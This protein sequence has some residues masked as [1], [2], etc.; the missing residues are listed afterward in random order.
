MR[1]LKASYTACLSTRCDLFEL[2]ESTTTLTI[3]SE[4]VG[5]ET[6]ETKT[7]SFR[8]TAGITDG[9]VAS[10]VGSRSLN[11]KRFEVWPSKLLE[12]VKMSVIFVFEARLSSENDHIEV[13]R[14]LWS[15]EYLA[16]EAPLDA[17]EIVRVSNASRNFEGR[18]SDD[19]LF[20]AYLLLVSNCLKT[21][22][23]TVPIDFQRALLRR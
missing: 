5:D 10:I 13:L 19:E 15:N 6:A 9:T 22:L 23:Q 11:W 2:D 8:R 16:D 21:C 7:Y 12:Q 4:I 20:E 1:K 17:T 18:Q 14:T 3:R